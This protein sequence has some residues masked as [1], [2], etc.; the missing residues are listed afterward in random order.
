MADLTF[1]EH[2]LDLQAIMLLTS[3]NSHS[4]VERHGYVHKP[5]QCCPW[6]ANDM[7]L[8]LRLKQSF[9][10]KML[11]N[12][13]SL[14]LS[15]TA[16]QYDAVTPMLHIWEGV[17]WIKSLSI[18]SANDYGQTVQVLLHL[19]RHSSKRM[20]ITCEL[21]YLMPPTPLSVALLLSSHSVEPFDYP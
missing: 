2:R 15:Q 3:S 12:L 19:T 5:H 20:V 11:P 8:Q 14:F 18:Y 16:P 17:L 6:R 4:E 1:Y 7:L 13:W 10:L 9:F 21:Q